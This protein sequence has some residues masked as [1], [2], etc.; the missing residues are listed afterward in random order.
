MRRPVTPQPTNQLT[1]SLCIPARNEAASIGDLIDAARR[2]LWELG[3]VDEIVV[4]DDG[5]DD[6]TAFEAALAGATVVSSAALMIEVGPSC[7]KGDAM[8]RSLATST[9]ELIVWCD[10]DIRDFDVRRLGLLLQPLRSDPD[11]EMVKGYFR[12]V[13]ADGLPTDGGRVSELVARPLLSLL[14]PIAADI[15]EPLSG[16]FAM[17]RTAA[18]SLSFE[19]DYGVDI[20]LLLDTIAKWGRSSVVEVDLGVLAHRNQPLDRL[21]LQ[22]AAVERSILTR[23]GLD[24]AQLG[25][26]LR[27]PRHSSGGGIEVISAPVRRPMAEYR[28]REFSTR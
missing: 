10:G 4:I 23:C 28:C 15:R 6:L 21:A 5:S 8:W 25:K 18:E 14:M 1:A 22:A 26:T 3:T 2:E 13:N 7:G 9:G 12:R 20:G 17:R 24:H 16:M 11:I 19:S 27:R